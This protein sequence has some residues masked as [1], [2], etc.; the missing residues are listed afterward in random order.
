MV[1]DTSAVLAILGAETEAALFIEKSRQP[2]CLQFPVTRRRLMKA[3]ISIPNPVYEA[4]KQLAQQLGLS[5]SELYTLALTAYVT[6]HQQ[7]DVTA[8]LNRVYDTESSTLEPGLV[9]L[10]LATLGGET[11]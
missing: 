2:T 5:L 3:N 6:A 7:E 11:W 8:A 4:T 1:I 9:H 10:Q